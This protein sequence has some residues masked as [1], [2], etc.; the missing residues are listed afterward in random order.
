MC[1]RRLDIVRYIIIIIIVVVVVVVVVVII[2]IILAPVAQIW[3]R[4]GIGFVSIIWAFICGEEMYSV[5]GG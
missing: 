2:A 3:Y 4:N 5:C 1:Y